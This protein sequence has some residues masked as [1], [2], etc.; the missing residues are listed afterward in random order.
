MPTLVPIVLPI[1]DVQGPLELPIM[2]DF[3]AS[4]R[5]RKCSE[6]PVILHSEKALVEHL[7]SHNSNYFTF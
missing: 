2:S 1:P 4:G 6:C 3:V 5:D 7:L